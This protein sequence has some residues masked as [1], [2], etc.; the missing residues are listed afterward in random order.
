MEYK[1]DNEFRFKN[2]PDE[3]TPINADNLNKALDNTSWLK[4]QLDG[5][6]EQMSGSSIEINDSAEAMLNKLEIEGKSYQETRSGKNLINIHGEGK[7]TSKSVNNI[8]Q[9]ETLTVTTTNDTGTCICYI[10][11]DYEINRPLT[12]SFKAKYL[13]GLNI[14]NSRAY[15]RKGGLTSNLV[16]LRN[17]TTTELSYKLTL[18]NGLPEEGYDLWFYIVQDGTLEH[19]TISVK[20]SDIQVEYGEEATDYEPYGASPSPDYP[21]KIKSVGKLNEQGKYEIE[22]TIT[23]DD[24]S[25]TTTFVL[26]EPLRSL[27]NGKRDLLYIKGG[28]LYVERKIKEL[29]LS[30]NDNWKFTFYASNGYNDYSLTPDNYKGT[31]T[32]NLCTHFKYDPK[33][34]SKAE[35]NTVCWS[36][37]PDVYEMLVFKIS[38][39]LITNLDAWKNFLIQEREKGTLIKVIYELKNSIIEDLGEIEMPSTY[40]DKSTITTT[41]ELEP[42][43]NLEYVK[44]TIL[45]NYVEKRLI[46]LMK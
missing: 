44:D 4:Q 12:L 33:S 2:L 28:R 39:D 21:S 29:V 7:V 11:F 45:T 16:S 9:N 6:I 38:T 22:L 40:K 1:F 27:S 35:I 19:D 15:F 25:K 31:A 5:T 13:E 42:T 46:N 3:S 32:S 10:H 23:K 20:F 24:E 34:F 17:D 30:E 43:I 41:D 18:K 36:G 14:T 26:N 37:N 8:I